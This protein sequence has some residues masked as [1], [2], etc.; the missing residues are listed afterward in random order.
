MKPDRRLSAL[1]LAAKSSRRCRPPAQRA[2][3]TNRN[4]TSMRTANW[5]PAAGPQ[6]SRAPVLASTPGREGCCWNRRVRFI[7]RRR[8]MP[9]GWSGL[10]SGFILSCTHRSTAD[11]TGRRPTRKSPATYPSFISHKLA[12]ETPKQT[13]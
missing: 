10:N 3:R 11:N 12:V 6:A 13:T 5:S 7:D 8:P 2:E 4:V 9:G 1:L